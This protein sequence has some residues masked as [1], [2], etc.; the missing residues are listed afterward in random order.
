MID[1]SDKDKNLIPNENEELESPKSENS[2][3]NYLHYTLPVDDIYTVFFCELHNHG[4]SWGLFLGMFLSIF[5]QVNMLVM[6]YS[7]P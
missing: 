4:F 2:D 7:T 1:T 5:I 6:I 3:K